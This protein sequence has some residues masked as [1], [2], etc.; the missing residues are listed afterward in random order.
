[1]VRDAFAKAKQSQPHIQTV[2]VV[3]LF[4]VNLKMNELL[5]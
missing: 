5:K 4:G 2:C 1:M 3:G